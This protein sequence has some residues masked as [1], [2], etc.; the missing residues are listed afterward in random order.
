MS[1][2]PLIDFR[3]KITEETDWYLDSAAESQGCDRSEIARE[4]LH[5]AAMVA[6]HQTIL[7][8]K[9]LAAK[10]MLA[11]PN[12][13]TGAYPLAAGLPGDERTKYLASGKR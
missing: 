9:H 1:D 5:K 12:G 10:G 7:M 13:M 3:G 8:N 6:I 11:A 2:E 4:I